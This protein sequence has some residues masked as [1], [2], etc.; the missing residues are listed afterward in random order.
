MVMSAESKLPRIVLVDDH[1]AVLHQTVELLTRQFEIVA[2]L[3]NG[4][5]LLALAP[6][7]QIDA[8]V[9]DITL[10]GLSGIQVA[11]RLKETHFPG[12]IVMLTVH[13][14]PDYAREALEV[15]ALGYVVKPRLASDLVPALRAALGGKV[16]ISP[17][18]ELKEF[19]ASVLAR[20]TS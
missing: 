16:F 11:C 5:E 2:A 6:D 1:P 20:E 18:P 14:D 10:P 7:K 4:R 8:V 19:S 9:L 17:C 3:H 15:G 13:L 12:K